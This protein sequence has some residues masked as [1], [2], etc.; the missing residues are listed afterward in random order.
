MCVRLSPLLSCRVFGWFS[1]VLCS[2]VGMV[3]V[4]WEGVSGVC[5]VDLGLRVRY[6]WGFCWSLSGCLGS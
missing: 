1:L 6:L 2:F 4:D 3:A 5:R